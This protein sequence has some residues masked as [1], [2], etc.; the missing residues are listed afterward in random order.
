MLISAEWNIFN[1]FELLIVDSNIC[2]SIC[3][4]IHMR[5]HKGHLQPEEMFTEMKPAE[6]IPFIASSSI[7]DGRR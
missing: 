3:L 2:G 5:K 7:Q 4:V 6:E 1:F